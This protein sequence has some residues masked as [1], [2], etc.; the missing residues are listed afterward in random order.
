M[1]PAG[2][3]VQADGSVYDG[4][5][6]GGVRHG[7][8]AEVTSTGDKYRGGWKDGRRHGE[9]I[10]LYANGDCYKGRVG[11]RPRPFLN[12]L[13]TSCACVCMCVHTL[14]VKWCV[15]GA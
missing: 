10:C 1:A 15:R 2:R 4:A 13:Y 7:W 11:G 3:L 5:L 8:G 9:G 6:R 12:C 14:C